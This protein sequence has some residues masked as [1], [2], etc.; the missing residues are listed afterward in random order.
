MSSIPHASV[1]VGSFGCPLAGFE[2][3]E[4]PAGRRMPAVGRQGQREPL[5]LCGRPSLIAPGQDL[6][7]MVVP[8]PQLADVPRDP[9]SCECGVMSRPVSPVVAMQG[10]AGQMGAVHSEPE[11]AVDRCPEGPRWAFDPML[12]EVEACLSK[13]PPPCP[14]LDVDAT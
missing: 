10:G 14:F 5:L 3:H 4:E 8:R 11:L 9:M 7:A 13:R 2:I 1:L 6:E 12:V